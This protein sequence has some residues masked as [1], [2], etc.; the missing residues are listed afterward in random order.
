MKELRRFT[1]ITLV[2][3]SLFFSACKKEI[4]TPNDQTKLLFGS[5]EW[6][7]SSGGG[8][9]SPVTATDETR[10]TLEFKKNGKFTIYQKGKKEGHGKFKFE[11]RQSI[12]SGQNEQIIVYSNQTG[13]AEMHKHQS[14]R[15]IDAETLDLSNE[16]YDCHSS[17]YKRK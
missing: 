17:R 15:F 13:K 16:C 1:I 11:K 14:F 8:W 5:W 6:V 2:F 12:F 3:S 4:A 9:G 7:G 10:Y